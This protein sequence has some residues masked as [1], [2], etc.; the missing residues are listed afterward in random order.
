MRAGKRILPA[1]RQG[2]GRFAHHGDQ[3]IERPE[4]FKD[5]V[6]YS[7]L[8]KTAPGCGEGSE[9]RGFSETTHFSV[10]DPKMN[11]SFLHGR[12]QDYREK[13]P[14]HLAR[15]LLSGPL[16]TVQKELATLSYR[17]SAAAIQTSMSC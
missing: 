5:H 3:L 16:G 17:T 6:A 12:T 15:A 4:R 9:R 7:S 11:N 8:R 14:V 10:N 13:C 2:L 1:V